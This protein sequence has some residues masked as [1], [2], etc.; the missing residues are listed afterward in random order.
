M[1]HFYISIVKV[2]IVEQFWQVHTLWRRQYYYC[3]TAT[4]HSLP[5]QTHIPLS[6]LSYNT[7]LLHSQWSLTTVCLFFPSIIPYLNP[8]WPG[9]S[10]FQ[11]VLLLSFIF[12]LPPIIAVA[13]CFGIHW[14][15]SISSSSFHLSWKVF[16][17]FSFIFPF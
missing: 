14:F 11:M 8:L 3:T 12:S 15:C 13:F 1:S 10:I 5:S 17:N 6:T 9:P 2:G 4:C 7:I 16:V